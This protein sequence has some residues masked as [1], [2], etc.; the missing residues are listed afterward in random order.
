[1]DTSFLRRSFQQ[2]FS[3]LFSRRGQTAPTAHSF[4]MMTITRLPFTTQA[5]TAKGANTSS[6]MGL[7]CPAQG[8]LALPWVAE[9]QLRP[10]LPSLCIPTLSLTAWV[11]PTKFPEEV[12]GIDNCLKKSQ[13]FPVGTADGNPPL[14]PTARDRSNHCDGLGLGALGYF[15]HSSR[16]LL[17]DDATLFT[18]VWVQGNQTRP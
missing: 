16:A 18:Q 10:R 14:A 11:Q 2:V 13:L 15:L 9:D 1:M 6:K 12:Q 8:P 4:A 17:R 7:C 5:P 3:S